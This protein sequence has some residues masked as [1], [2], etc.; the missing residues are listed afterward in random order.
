[1]KKYI[2]GFV[3]GTI[4][5]MSTVAF[6]SDSIK[7]FLFPSK[8]MFHSNNYIK[9]IDGSDVLNYKNRAYV[10]LRSFAEGMGAT[11][12]YQ[13]SIN[14][15]SIDIFSSTVPTNNG[16]TLKDP[17]GYVS[18]GNLDVVSNGK[19]YNQ[20][21]SGSIQINKDLNGK[22]IELDVL[23]KQGQIIGTSDYVFILNQDIDQPKPGDIR[24][25]KTNINFDA[26]QEISYRV[27]VHDIL[28]PVHNQT[29]DP[30]NGD[31]IAVMF[32]PPFNFSG[33]LS[34]GN[35]N[36]FT[37][38][39]F[40]TSD[41]DITVQ[42]I[43]LEFDVYT[44]DAQDNKKSLVYSYKLPTISGTLASKSG[45]REVTPWNQ[46]GSNG[47]YLTPGNYIVELKMP[48]NI[49]YTLKGSNDVK[50]YEVYSQSGGTAFH[51]GYS[52]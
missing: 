21:T 35:I 7:A 11:V 10:P 22:V 9:E 46:R 49:N 50:T 18:I 14:L 27:S 29:I 43:N 45:Y 4:L 51:V 40:N 33:K 25:F 1:M 23:N 32:A 34:I 6:A 5:S 48:S 30:K 36:S 52:S 12:N 41:T 26:N 13:A 20:I 17:D 39:V 3:C 24:Q 19:Y 38:D 15:N 31:P 44:T 2:I 28:K 42:P 37:V 8:V 47:Q 16:L